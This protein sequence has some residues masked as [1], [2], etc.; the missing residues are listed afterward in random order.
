MTID[1]LPFNQLIGLKK[2]DPQSGFLVY[3]PNH[4]QYTNHLGTIH[5]S[6]LLAV[7]EAGAGEF[8]LQNFKDKASYTPVVR[9]LEAKFRKPASG[10]ISAKSNTDNNVVKTKQREF[11]EKGRTF[12]PVSVEVVDES[13]QVALTA[14]VELFIKSNQKN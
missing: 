3:L 14:N 10:K 12:L 6:A 9:K 13:D 5:A 2:C 4:I 1:A 11:N 7:A 8:L